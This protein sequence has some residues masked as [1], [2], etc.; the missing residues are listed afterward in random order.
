MSDFVRR[1]LIEEMWGKEGTFG[2]LLKNNNTIFDNNIRRLQEN[3][4]SFE[5]IIENKKGKVI[6]YDSQSYNMTIIK[7]EKEDNNSNDS[8]DNNDNNNDG[9]NDDDSDIEIIQTD[10]SNRPKFNWLLAIYIIL[11][12][13]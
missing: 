4:L 10:N 3:E 11:S 8:N 13:F 6:K 12:F 7:D 5:M 1:A 9:V 2:K